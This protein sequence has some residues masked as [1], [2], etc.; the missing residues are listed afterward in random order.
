MRNYTHGGDKYAALWSEKESLTILDFSAN[1]NPLGMPKNVKEKTMA[2][3]EYSDAYPDPFARKL[4]QKICEKHAKNH[5]ME[6]PNSWVV[7][8]NGAADLIF[9]TVYGLD[10]KK[11]LIPSPTFS[12]Y[13]DALREKNILVENFYLK[14]ENNFEFT[15]EILEKLENKLEEKIDGVFICN[16]NNPVGNLINPRLMD[17]ILKKSKERNIYAFVD[18]CFLELTGKERD[19]SLVP[20]L[21]DY[22]NL[23]IFKAFTKTYAMAGLRL[24]YIISSNEEITDKIFSIG[25]PWSVSTPAQAG[26]IAALDENYYVEKSVA[27]IKEQRKILEEFLKAWNFKVYKGYANYIFFYHKKG[28]IF[29]EEMKKRGILIRNCENYRGLTEGYMR[30]AIKSESENRIFMERGKEILEWLNQ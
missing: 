17:E 16:P 10:L 6:I 12:E 8:G 28:K 23:V 9:R 11:V 7:C 30:I 25:Q 15:E 2:S 27:Y 4:T 19:Y 21:K 20:K 26:G 1:T 29:L 3:I 22:D 14:E 24:G 13:E 5:G 18:E